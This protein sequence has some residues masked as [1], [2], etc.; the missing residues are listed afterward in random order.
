MEIEST[1]SIYKAET[2]KF[3]SKIF[4]LFNKNTLFTSEKKIY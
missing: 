1:V 2:E 4:K 3:I